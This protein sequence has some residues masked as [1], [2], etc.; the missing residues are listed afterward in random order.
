MAE[1]AK[2]NGGSAFDY[3]TKQED[4]NKLWTARHK[5][6]YAS[7]NLI[8]GS[9]S[10]TTDVCVPIS[11]LPEIVDQTSEDIVKTGVTG[12][13]REEEFIIDL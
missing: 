5:L 12:W 1:L 2:A 6:F 10:V 13:L 8:P 3:A 7:L 9:K 11:K 4:R